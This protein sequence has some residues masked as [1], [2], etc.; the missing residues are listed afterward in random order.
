MAQTIIV[1]PARLA[2]TRLP[3][4]PLADING[5]PMIIRVMEQ[6]Y[7]ANLGP[8]LVACCGSEI[9]SVVES[10]GGIA[11]ETEPNLPSGS[12]RI[13]AALRQYDPNGSYD[14]VINLQGDLPL[15]PPQDIKASLI[16]ISEYGYDIGTLGAQIANGADIANPN[17]VKIATS[18]WQK[19]HDLAIA[20]A[21]Y[22]SRLPVPANADSHYH[23][24]GIYAYKRLALERFV[25]LPPSHLE[26]IE[27]L[28]QLRALEDGMKIGVG[29]TQGVPLSVDTPED[30]ECVK[31]IL[32]QDIA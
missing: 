1:I 18:A 12:D 15:I 14:Q 11:L 13:V 2:S 25:D 30:L 23:H 17:V 26:K 10:H 24:I 20:R 6:A 16:P 8:V 4:K 31:T 22:F 3:N 29:L 19:H 28:E 7:A 21:I 32:N 5:K 9:R 27:K